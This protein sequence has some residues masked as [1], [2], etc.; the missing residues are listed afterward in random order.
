MLILRHEFLAEYTDRKNAI[1]STLVNF[2]IPNCD[3]SV[4]RSVGLPATIGVKPIL[5]GKIAFT[6]LQVRVVPEIYEPVLAELE[7]LEIKFVETWTREAWT[8]Q[9]RPDSGVEKRFGHPSQVGR[10][11]LRLHDDYTPGVLHHLN[12][13]VY[14]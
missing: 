2:G 3:T 12:G 1:T 5:E 4:A 10:P 11:N 7:A 14:G 13:K 8:L 9:D 6:G